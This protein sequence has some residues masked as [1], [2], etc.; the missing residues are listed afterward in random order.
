MKYPDSRRAKWEADLT[1]RYS[2]SRLTVT[3]YIRLTE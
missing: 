2:P 3:V 1:D